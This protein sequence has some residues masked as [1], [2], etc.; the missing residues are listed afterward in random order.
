MRHSRK[1]ES[2]RADKEA[3]ERIA[4]ERRAAAALIPRVRALGKINEE[5]GEQLATMESRR[6][7]IA[8]ECKT[9]LSSSLTKHAFRR[10]W[11]SYQKHPQL[12]FCNVS[13]IV[14][15]LQSLATSHEVPHMPPECSA[16]LK[17]LDSMD[18]RPRKID[19]NIWTN[20]VA[21]RRLKVGFKGCKM[22]GFEEHR[23]SCGFSHEM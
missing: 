6:K 17:A 21:L 18:S 14:D 15:L 12:V 22:A 11:K 13:Y 4:R 23:R 16:F 7:A 8:K 20:F 3:S 10:L 1:V 19:A 5:L 2:L 9:W